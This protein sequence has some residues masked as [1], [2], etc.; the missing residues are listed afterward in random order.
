MDEPMPG[1][2]PRRLHHHIVEG[3]LEARLGRAGNGVRQLGERVAQA[4]LGGDEGERI[5]GG[6]RGERRAA[7]E[8][9]ID[10]D[11]AVGARLRVERVLDVAL[12]DHA[13]M[14]HGADRDLAQQVVFAVGERLARRHHD[15]LAR[16]D[17]H[18]VE[19]LH[20]ADH[21]AVVEAVA[22]HFVFELLPADEVFL[23]QHLR[24]VGEP[25]DYPL[26][27]LRFVRAQ[28]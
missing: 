24:A 16:M 19:V 2:A 6:L 25:L 5:A 22:H 23:D 20:V 28:A 9:R 17:A 12:A 15:A 1:S 21:D 4:E 13:E 7:R 14:A 11:H 18:R 10:L 27:Q 26:A 3:G 8:A